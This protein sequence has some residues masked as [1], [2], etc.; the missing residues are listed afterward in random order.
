MVVLRGK[1]RLPSSLETVTWE[2]GGEG[3]GEGAR[4]WCGFWLTLQGERRRTEENR[5]AGT[6]WPWE[7]KEGEWEGAV[8]R[9]RRE[10]GGG[11]QLLGRAT[12]IWC[13]VSYE[14]LHSVFI[15][16]QSG[17]SSFPLSR[18]SSRCRSSWPRLPRNCSLALCH[19]LANP[20]PAAVADVGS[21][22]LLEFYSPK[23]DSK[24]LPLVSLFFVTLRERWAVPRAARHSVL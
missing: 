1:R 11:R 8:P 7:A 9:Q 3:K 5:H 12:H 6:T 2:H 21:D 18:R 13:Y 14:L 15:Q 23:L 10:G 4:G 24:T 16:T 19:V 22:G 20:V 17:N